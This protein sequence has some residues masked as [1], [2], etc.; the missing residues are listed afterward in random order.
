M[1]ALGWSA[2]ELAFGFLQTV[3][4]VPL[5]V[6]TLLYI[7][8][9]V[10]NLSCEFN[11][12][13]SL[14]IPPS[15][16][17]KP[18]I[19]QIMSLL[20]LGGDILRIDLWYPGTLVPW[21]PWMPKSAGAQ[22]PFI[23][24]YSTISPPFPRIPNVQIQPKFRQNSTCGWLNPWNPEYEG[25]TVSYFIFYYFYLKPVFLFFL[26]YVLIGGKL[27]YNIVLVSTYNNP[28]VHE[29]RAYCSSRC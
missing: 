12:I 28:N 3:S 8:F 5:P 6:L 24:W 19:E 9:I 11:F 2:W 4:Y 18:N 29:V 23:R 1:T 25:P 13:L 26:I 27:L 15:R 21:P 17:Y 7:P 16:N 20:F 22:V 10:I 14:I